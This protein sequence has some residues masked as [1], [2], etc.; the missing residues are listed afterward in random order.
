M[1]EDVDYRNLANGSG[2]R[3]KVGKFTFVGVKLS[4]YAKS[5]LDISGAV[6]LLGGSGRLSKDKQIANDWLVLVEE[7]GNVSTL[8]VWEL[9]QIAD[10]LAMSTGAPA[11][12][13]FKNMHT[14]DKEE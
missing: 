14:A 11:N 12:V 8:E 2:F 3:L 7:G 9:Q 1:S 6:N 4:G 5:S 13:V 10:K